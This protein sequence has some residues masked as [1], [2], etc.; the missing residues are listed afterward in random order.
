MSRSSCY[1][2]PATGQ[3]RALSGPTPCLPLK[4]QVEIAEKGAV[5]EQEKVQAVQQV[6]PDATVVSTTA[7]RIMEAQGVNL[8][9]AQVRANIIQRLVDGEQLDVKEINK[10]DPTNA[11]T[12]ALFTELTGVQFPA[13]KV[14]NEQLY[15]IYRSAA[16]VQQEQAAQVEAQLQ[17]TE[18]AQPVQAET[19]VETPVVETPVQEN[20]FTLG[21]EVIPYAEGAQD[22]ARQVMAEATPARSAATGSRSQ[23]TRSSPKPTGPDSPRPARRTWPWHTSST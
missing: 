14:P 21:G 8:K 19:A 7:A 2:L 18:T 6:N 5:T 1:S 20:S 4:A 22:R 11:E 16:Q 15:A 23:A 12:K 17:E 3:R 10:I 9:T 13:E